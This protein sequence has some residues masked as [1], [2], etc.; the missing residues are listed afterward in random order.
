MHVFLPE[1]FHFLVGKNRHREAKAWVN[2]CNVEKLSFP[3]DN[4]RICRPMKSH[5]GESFYT[6]VKGLITNTKLIFRVCVF[7]FLWTTDVLVYFGMSLFS[8]KLV[9]NHYFNYVAIGLI[10][11]PAYAF[12]PIL[13][14]KIGRRLTISTTHIATAIAF[15]MA[16]FILTHN[17]YAQLLFWLIAKFAISAAFMGI[18]VYAAESFPTT[19]RSVCVGTCSVC[20][21][22]FGCLAPF[23]QTTASI[24]SPL[25]LV[26]FG[27]IS[28]V[29]GFVTLLLPE[30]KDQQLPDSSDSMA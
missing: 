22:L 1:S 8:V 28:A 3:D 9:G 5:E 27:A 21:K 30:T 12:G 11:I 16:A 19:E 24:W 29:A 18:F 6:Q 2:K 14:D 15:T 7:S 17:P 10:E 4:S 26:I 13:L 20:G 23:I 25:P